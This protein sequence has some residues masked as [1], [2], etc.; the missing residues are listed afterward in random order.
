MLS[1]TMCRL[2]RPG[3]DLSD[4]LQ[5]EVENGHLLEVE[6]ARIYLEPDVPI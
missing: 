1:S 4:G 3:R 2:Y 5:K 6:S